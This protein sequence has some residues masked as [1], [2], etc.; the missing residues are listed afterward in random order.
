MRRDARVFLIA[1]CFS[2]AAISQSQEAAIQRKPEITGVPGSRNKLP[3]P[4]QR[5]TVSAGQMRISPKAQEKL[6]RARLL[7]MR[8]ET[9]KA[10]QQVEDILSET[11]DFAD[12][13]SVRARVNLH[14]NRIPE[15]L[16]DARRA[17]AADP[18]LPNAHFTLGEILNHEHRYE[19]ALPSL[20]R[21][22][23]LAPKVWPCRY[24][25]ARAL[26]GTVQLPVALQ[27][28]ERAAALGGLEQEP[29]AIYYLRGSVLVLLHDYNA[30]TKDLE[31]FL[32]LRSTGEVAGRVRMTLQHLRGPRPKSDAVENG[33]FDNSALNR[34]SATSPELF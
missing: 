12:A 10:R 16:A 33:L 25:R 23:A 6:R 3:N 27:E 19:E 7:L 22:I 18:Q 26:V 15:A 11:P 32:Q 5:E 20:E 1:I 24:E 8:G 30:G 9:D 29:E 13:I 17:L 31:S 4:S 28:I 2:V 34:G 21:C 14:E